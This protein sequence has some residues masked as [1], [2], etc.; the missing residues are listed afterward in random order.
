MSEQK[1]AELGDRIT[2]AML[3]DGDQEDLYKLRADLKLATLWADT[4]DQAKRT[5]EVVSRT[6]V[7]ATRRQL[8]EV[9]ATVLDGFDLEEQ[10]RLA[11]FLGA[12]RLFYSTGES[13]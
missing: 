7:A 1:I 2:V 13:L 10:A 5:T 8:Q 4:Y 9:R 3:I 6:D 12:E 11:H